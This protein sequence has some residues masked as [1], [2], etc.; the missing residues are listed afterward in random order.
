MIYAP[1]RG[2]TLIELM[3]SLSI[4]VIIMLAATSAY[5]SFISYNRQAQTTSTV[6]NSVSF[7]IDNMAREIR[8]G[9]NYRNDSTGF[10]FINADN[11]SVT[12]TLQH[13]QSICGTVVGTTPSCIARVSCANLN[14]TAVTD[15]NIKINSLLFNP[16]G[17]AIGL[18]D[19]QPMVTIVVGG[20]A[21]VPNTDCTGS[22][23]IT[24]QIETAATQRLP[25][26]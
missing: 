13:S 22:G 26:L 8:S 5:L 20:E 16:R 7:S 15:S 11:C 3:V 12:Y 4:F 25:D 9:T 24:F 6:V 10:S 17:T 21:C 19:G 14:P 18:S 1:S 23:K 2:F